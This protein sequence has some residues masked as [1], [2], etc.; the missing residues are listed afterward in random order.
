MR[1]SPFGN[2]RKLASLCGLLRNST[3]FAAQKLG[4]KQCSQ[5]APA[6]AGKLK[7]GLIVPKGAEPHAPPYRFT[8]M[9][10]ELRTM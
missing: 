7:R 1:F 2:G 10:W 4:L 5:K 9:I 6:K 3:I 8:S